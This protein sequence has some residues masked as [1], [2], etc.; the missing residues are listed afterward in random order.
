MCWD[1]RKASG[2]PR[3]ALASRFLRVWRGR[4]R[5]SSAY[6]E[7]GE[8]VQARCRL[9]V[10]EYPVEIGHAVDTVRHRFAVEHKVVDV[11]APTAAGMAASS[12]VQGR[13][14]GLY[15]AAQGTRTL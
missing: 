8:R 5:G 13:P 3:R 4:G 10:A 1:S 11:V 7:E 6:L 9:A 14:I 12:V 2:A 15:K